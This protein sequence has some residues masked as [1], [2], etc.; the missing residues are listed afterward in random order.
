MTIAEKEKQ[1]LQMLDAYKNQIYRVCWGFTTNASEV[2]DI[3]QEVILNI[4]KGMDG[5][6]GDA[7]PS[8]W[9]YRIAVNTCILWQKK[10]LKMEPL[11]GN[12]LTQSV[13]ENE[14]FQFEP[15]PKILQLR[16]AIQ[17]LKKIDRSLILLVLEGFAYKEIA[18]ISGLSVSNVGARINRIKAKMREQIN[19]KKEL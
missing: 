3:F 4:W 6:R 10:A 5:F 8:T 19:N 16:A 11:E 7:M 12:Q 9:I 2:E 14:A 15:S 18:E 1:F 13:I 17:Q